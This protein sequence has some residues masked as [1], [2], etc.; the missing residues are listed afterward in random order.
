MN[1]QMDNQVKLKLLD[2]HHLQMI[3]ETSCKLL[4]ECGVYFEIDEALEI[5]RAAGLH[6]VRDS[7]IIHFSRKVV[8]DAINST[9]N[10]FI[11]KGAVPQFDLEIGGGQLYLGAGSLPLYIVDCRSRSRKKGCYK[12]MLRFLCLVNK[13][14]NL[15]IG[16][17]VIKPS[18]VPDS[19]I[20]A[21]WDQVTVKH[22]GKPACC[23]YADQYDIAHDTIRILTAAAGSLEELKNKKTWALTSCPV[24]CL[25]WGHSA[26]G[27][28]EMAK[29]G[30]PVEIMD[31]PF[32]GSLSPVTLAGTIALSNANVLAGLVLA[33]IINPG[34]PLIYCFYGGTMDMKV[35]NHVFGTP[36]AAL[37]TAAASQLCHM[38][39]IPSNMTVP[40]VS[41]KIPDAQCSY[42]K[43]MDALLPAL[44]G[45]DCL[46][47]FGGVLDFGLSASY[48]QM[49]IDNEMA[50]Q[51]IHIRKGF[52]VTSGTLA[53]DVIKSVGPGGNFLDID[54]T[55][56]H[57]KKDLYIP[58]LA[59]RSVFEVWESQG[60]KDILQNAECVIKEIFKNPN[61]ENYLSPE[62]SSEVDHV[63]K[64]ILQR[65]N[66]EP[67][68][69]N[70]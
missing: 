19:V 25:K 39:K 47:L 8:E 57:F 2:D 70:N 67:T 43:M 15:S 53:A 17:A 14:D 65:E 12:D 33:Q 34:T 48:E 28:L 9:P 40:A 4:E 16:N 46:S 11:R 69:L 32:P 45:V 6:V 3:H 5:A 10:H 26:I 21:I 60:S 20:H 52:E 23:W 55:L 51:I 59:D 1:S 24:G 62:C 54:H 7:H 13:C 41:A 42:E 61:P 36:E 50:G 63:V 31:T 58:R 38:Y 68:W 30:V 37:Y 18:D 35:A 27:L 49:L 56:H 22:M 64:E 29:V 66:V 44:S